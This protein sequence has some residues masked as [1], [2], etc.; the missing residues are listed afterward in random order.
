MLSRPQQLRFKPQ[1]SYRNITSSIKLD[2]K[3]S[4]IRSMKIMIVD[5]DVKLL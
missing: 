2:T 3:N 1:L 4:P 5:L